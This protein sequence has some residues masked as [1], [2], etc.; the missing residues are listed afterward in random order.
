MEGGV[1]FKLI[2]EIRLSH[3]VV[4][5]II[6]TYSGIV[7]DTRLL[8][9]EKTRSPIF[10]TLLGIVIDVKLLHFRNASSSILITLSGIVIDVRLLHTEKA[11]SPIFITLSGNGKLFT[12]SILGHSDL[13]EVRSS[14][15]IAI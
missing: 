12:R 6:V 2:T 11:S 9:C 5:S 4:S 3:P 8:H 7:M 10:V 1:G 13:R 15:T 14:D